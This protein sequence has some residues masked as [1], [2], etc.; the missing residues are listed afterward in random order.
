MSKR[1]DSGRKEEGGRRNRE[2]GGEQTELSPSRSKN[3]L[4]PCLFVMVS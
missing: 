2:D 3:S 4:G 1:S